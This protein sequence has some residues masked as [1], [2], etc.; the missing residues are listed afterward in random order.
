MGV[1]HLAVFGPERLDVIGLH[2]RREQRGHDADGAARIGDIDRL[3]LVVVRMDL[4]RRV[5]TARWRRR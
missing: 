1:G 3:A 5:H 2:L 4:H